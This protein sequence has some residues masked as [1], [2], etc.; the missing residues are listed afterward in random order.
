[1]HVCTNF[2]MRSGSSSPSCGWPVPKNAA[3]P[4]TGQILVATAGRISRAR[5]PQ[6]RSTIARPHLATSNH[7]RTHPAIPDAV[8][9]K[10]AGSTLNRRQNYPRNPAIVL[11]DTFAPS[12][13]E[14]SLERTT[15]PLTSAD[16]FTATQ[17]ADTYNLNRNAA[18]AS[19]LAITHLQPW[20]IR[21][22]RSKRACASKSA[23][24]DPRSPTPASGR[25]RVSV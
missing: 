17:S 19:A 12:D 3:T 14:P 15:T 18:P 8:P 16:N 25:R 13:I 7:G 5:I 6:S 1:M 21:S 4:S 20:Q 2:I 22:A 10:A 11:D 24:K 9:G 23:S